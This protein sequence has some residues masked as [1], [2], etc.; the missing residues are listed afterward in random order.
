MVGFASEGAFAGSENF[1]VNGFSPLNTYIARRTPNGWATESAL[2]PA[3]V[4]SKPTKYGFNGDASLDLSTLA[5]CG[6]VADFTEGQGGSP[7]FA[8]AIREP[9]GTW[10]KTPDYTDLTGVTPSQNPLSLGSS[11]DLSHMVWQPDAV[12]LLPGD[13]V[14]GVSAI[15]ETTGLGTA[16][17][18]LRMVSVNNENTPLTTTTQGSKEDPYLGAATRTG[19]NGAVYQAISSDGQTVYFTAE[20][21]GGGPLTLYARTGDFAGGTPASPTTVTI[22]EGE[23]VGASA[24]GSMA[25]G[26]YELTRLPFTSAKTQNGRTARKH[27]KKTKVKAS[28]KDSNGSSSKTM[29]LKL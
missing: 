19:H 2:A 3:S 11:S 28:V 17:P 8:C 9:G 20:P 5:T 10:A 6:H 18:Q 25:W 29:T 21:A 24:D 12:G 22:A 1:I 15:Y 26:N 16:S 23:Y 4:I 13:N 14:P 7:T 27:H